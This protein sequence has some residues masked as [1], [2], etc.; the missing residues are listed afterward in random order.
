ML[1]AKEAVHGAEH[2]VVAD[3]LQALSAACSDMGSAAEAAVLLERALAMQAGS[4][5]E[6][7]LVAAGYR[8]GDTTCPAGHALL[9]FATPHDGFSCDVCGAV[10]AVGAAMAG[11]RA[12]D[13]DTC[14]TCVQ[15][16][17]A[18]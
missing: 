9:A 8:A 10:Q 18:I 12:C 14:V 17:G 15:Q 6:K 7:V 16:E 3:A 1:A 4:V 2:P 5:V 11:C 13:Y